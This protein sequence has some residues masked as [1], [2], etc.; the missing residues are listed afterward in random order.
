M[1]YV[2]P[3]FEKIFQC[4]NRHQVKY[5]IIGGV[6]VNLHGYFRATGDLDIAIALTDT[7]LGKF[8]QCVKELGMKPR[9]PVALDD[10]ADAEKRRE[11]MEQ[12][13]MKVFSVYHPKD[14]ADHIDVMID[15]VVPFDQLYRNRV[16]MED[17]GLPLPVASIADLI[18]MKTHAGRG[19]DLQ[20]IK[21]L[22]KILELLDED[23]SQK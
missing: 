10:L 5:V 14:L 2:H 6:A 17:L 16:V 18:T 4:F 19:N 9:L 8:I 22:R 15:Q 13:N 1:G 12:K 7:E 20:D 23:T 3:M 21:A 11:W